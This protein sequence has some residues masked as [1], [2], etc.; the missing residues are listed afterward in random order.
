MMPAHIIWLV[1]FAAIIVG[2]GLAV[3]WL[4]SSIFPPPDKPVVQKFNDMNEGYRPFFPTNPPV[5]AT[6]GVDRLAGE[7]ALAEVM[8]TAVK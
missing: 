6:L 3:A 2:L 1:A 5:R 4:W 7:S 8:L